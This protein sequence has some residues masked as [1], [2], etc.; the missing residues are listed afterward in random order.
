MVNNLI[1]RATDTDTA[2]ERVQKSLG[3]NAYIIEIKNVGN[4]VE[5]TAS[6]EEPVSRPKKIASKAGKT[7]TPTTDKLPSLDKHTYY[8]ETSKS[9]QNNSKTSNI[10]IPSDQLKVTD[11]SEERELPL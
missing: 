3:P 11:Q 8:T 9:D 6:L 7:L 2:L 5:I 1:F 10:V 4:F